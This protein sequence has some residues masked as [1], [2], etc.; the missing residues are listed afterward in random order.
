MVRRKEGGYKREPGTLGLAVI[1]LSCNL[2]VD[3]HILVVILI[4]R[5][6]ANLKSKYKY[7]NSQGNILKM[8]VFIQNSSP[9]NYFINYAIVY[10]LEVTYTFF[11]CCYVG[12]ELTT[13][14]SSG[15]CCTL[16]MYI[17][18]P[19]ILFVSVQSIVLWF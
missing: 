3:V 6:K 12:I 15:R 2:T 5:Q 7:M 14:S 16:M 8:G 13:L 1:K 10:I 11:C 9:F 18:S 4:S 19:L 17:L